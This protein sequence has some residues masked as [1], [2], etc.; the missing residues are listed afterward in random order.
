[1]VFFNINIV[2]YIWN[3]FLL[4]IN[5]FRNQNWLR[6]NIYEYFKL[7]FVS[8]VTRHHIKLNWIRLVL[9]WKEQTPLGGWLLWKIWNI[10]QR[11]PASL[12]ELM[13]RTPPKQP[14]TET[15]VKQFDRWDRIFE[16]L[17]TPKMRRNYNFIRTKMSLKLVGFGRN[18]PRSVL[19]INSELN[20]LSR[21]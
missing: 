18:T 13:K 9:R 3:H 11:R 2:V 10:N 14:S 1:M 19:S 4:L 21:A 7:D 20:L 16:L 15:K 6:R 8:S 17:K 5:K 12:F